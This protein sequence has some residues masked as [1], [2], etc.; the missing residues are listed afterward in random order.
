MT[1]RCHPASLNGRTP[2]TTSPE[3]SGVRFHEA[4]TEADLPLDL[5]DTAT[6]V[7]FDDALRISHH[8]GYGTA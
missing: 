7:S 6:D 4:L 3:D 8:A 1:P 5:A 2:P